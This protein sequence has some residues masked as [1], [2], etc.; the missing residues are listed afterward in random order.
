MNQRVVIASA[1][2]SLMAL[3]LVAAPASAQEK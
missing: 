1:A 2:A 3:S